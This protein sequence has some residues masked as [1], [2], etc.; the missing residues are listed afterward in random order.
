MAAHFSHASTGDAPADPHKAVNRDDDVSLETKVGD[1]VHFMTKCKFGMMTTRDATSGT[2]D[3]RCM[4]I[5]ATETGGVDL[6]FYTNT[7]SHKT[8]ELASD[9]HINI[10]FSN[11]SGEWASIAGKAQIAADDRELIKKHYNPSLRAWVGDLGDG[12]HDG[13]ANDPRI[14]IIRVRADTATYSITSTGLLGHAAEV[15]RG[16][17]TGKP[18]HVNKLRELSRENIERWREANHLRQ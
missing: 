12:V 16:A 1:L 6:L 14:A 18:A 3:S 4:A 13:S 7:E 9:P 8:D 2:L 5:A 15:A 10:S 11:P 17:I